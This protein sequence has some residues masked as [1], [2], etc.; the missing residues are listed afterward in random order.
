MTSFAKLIK[1]KRRRRGLSLASLAALARTSAPY[2]H[3]LE[4]GHGLPSDD[5]VRRLIDALGLEVDKA[6]LAAGRVPPDVVRYFVRN[7]RA[8]DVVRRRMA[9]A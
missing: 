7:P 9:A 2:L 3:R 8:L 4:H 5:L 1:A 6:F